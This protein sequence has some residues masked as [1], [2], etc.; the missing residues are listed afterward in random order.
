MKTNGV[1][2]RYELFIHF[3]ILFIANN[4]IHGNSGRKPPQALSRDELN[5]VLSFVKNYAEIH[6]ILLPGRIPGL[7]DYEKVKLLPCNTSKGQLYLEYAESCEEIGIRACVES[8]FNSLWR[9]YLPYIHRAKPMTDLCI[10]CK[11]NSARIISTNLSAE[12][13][14]E[15]RYCLSLYTHTHTHTHLSL[16]ELLNNTVEIHVHVPLL[17]M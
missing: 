9:R 5:R 14:T 10:T 6:A 3:N 1:V 12:R 13:L 8:T 17:Y 16:T 7:K 4:R 11:D 15:V 2:T